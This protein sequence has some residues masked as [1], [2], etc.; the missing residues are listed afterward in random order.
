MPSPAARTIVVYP[1]PD[2]PTRGVLRY[3]ALTL[4]CRLGRAG[5]RYGKREGDGASPRRQT[6]ALVSVLYRADRVT[7]P[8]TR[9]S[10]RPIR[11]DDGWC[12]DATDGR[13]N[14][15]IRL[16][17]RASHEVMRRDDRLYDVVVILDW[18]LSRRA[19][20]RGSAI[21][22]HQTATPSRPTAGCVALEPAD[23]RRLLARL[24]LRATLMVR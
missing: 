24:P 18:N 1:R 22:L 15:P 14:R 16:P 12:D 7:R 6:L 2:D 3:G 8:P 20:G 4:A 13:Y 19:L 9:L 23:L 21:F 10:C 5:A 17:C 11:P